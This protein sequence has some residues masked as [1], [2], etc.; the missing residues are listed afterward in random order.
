[1]PF[2]IEGSQ[3][4]L[5]SGSVTVGLANSRKTIEGDMQFKSRNLDKLETDD[6]QVTVEC[7]PLWPVDPWWNIEIKNRLDRIHA[8]ENG[9]INTEVLVDAIGERSTTSS[10]ADFVLDFQELG[11]ATFRHRRAVNPNTIKKQLAEL[12]HERAGS[13]K[14]IEGQFQMIC[15]IW[16]EP[17]LRLLNYSIGKIPPDLLTGAPEGTTAFLLEETRRKKGAISKITNRVLVLVQSSILSD[18]S[19]IKELYQFTD[20]LCDV[21]EVDRAL[22]TDGFRWL[23][24]SVGMGLHVKPFDLREVLKDDNRNV[25]ENFLFNCAVGIQS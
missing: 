5:V 23:P 22:I 3:P 2:A 20:Q 10:L 17:V 1:M 13:L 19:H 8:S 4:S 7:P 15:N 21:V 18:K 16:L 25:F 11:R 12:V 6:L 14:G 24:H 9:K